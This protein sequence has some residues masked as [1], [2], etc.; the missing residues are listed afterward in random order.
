MSKLLAETTLRINS[1]FGFFR[2]KQF[3][4]NFYGK[5]FLNGEILKTDIFLGC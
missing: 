5:I 3:Y 2:G 4:S 1:H